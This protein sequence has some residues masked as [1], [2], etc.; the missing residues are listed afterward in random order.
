M[1]PA[2]RMAIS[3]DLDHLPEVISLIIVKVADTSE[4]QLEDFHSWRGWP[5]AAPSPIASTTS[6]T[7]SPRLGGADAVNAY[8]QIIDWL[9]GANNGGPLFI[10]GMADICMGRPYGVT[11]L[12][13]AEQEGDIQVSYVLSVLKYYKHGTTNDVFNHIWHI[14]GEDGDYYENDACVLGVHHRVFEEIDHVRWRKHI[15]HDHDHIHEI[16]M[17]EDSH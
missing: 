6:I 4:D 5:R 11:L 12:T 13:R 16:Q 9:Q 17:P 15:N 14:Y 7:T 1:E 10:M 8:L 3:N 2:K